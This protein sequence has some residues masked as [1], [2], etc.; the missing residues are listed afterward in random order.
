MRPEAAVCGSD[1]PLR[2][3]TVSAALTMLLC[4]QRRRYAV[5]HRLG[6]HRGHRTN[7]NADTAVALRTL[8]YAVAI[9]ADVVAV[10]RLS[11]RSAL[12]PLRSPKAVTGIGGPSGCPSLSRPRDN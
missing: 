3:R 5:A 8:Q 4:L 9:G 10:A 11:R 7:D 12:L 1:K 2:P 6:R